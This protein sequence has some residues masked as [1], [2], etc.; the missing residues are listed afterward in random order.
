MK[1]YELQQFGIDGLIL[2]DKPEPTPSVRQV[3][4]KV[5]AI[6]LNYRDLMVTKG[7]YNPRLKLPMIPFSDAAGEI[8]A[9]GG[10]V[11]GFKAGDR[12]A[13]TFFQNWTGGEPT[14]AKAR[15]AKGA[16]DAQGMM[17]E[18]VVLEETGAIHLPEHLSYEE[19][20]TLPCA[21]LTAWNAVVDKGQTK[22]GDTLLVQG[23]GG[24]SIFAAQFA[25]M[26]GARVIGTSSSDEKLERL[27][28]MGVTGGIN[29]KTSPDWDKA[30]KDLNG[31]AG[32]DHIVEVGG[33]GTL[34]RSLKAVRIGGIISVIGA[35]SS[36]SG[37]NPVLVLMKSIRLQGIFVG[38]REMFE[39]MNRA[40][41]LHKMKPVVYK[42]F[43]FEEAKQ[44]LQLMESGGHF[45]KIVIR[46]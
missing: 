9:V 44:A 25:L 8:V 26:H 12:V 30:A 2:V 13:G 32:I 23:T 27:A 7:A 40:V 16:G 21:G 43:P 4:V 37:I 24:V 5:H 6:S 35:L 42:V 28:A 19:G 20:A 45:G 14:E 11:K 29:Y 15:T 18:Y 3:V 22:A 31:G 33:A 39:A 1:A 36:G 41:S 46:L 38:H 10:E 34:E 17:A